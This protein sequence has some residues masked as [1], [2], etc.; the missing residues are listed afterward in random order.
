MHSDKLKQREISGEIISN[1][2]SNFSVSGSRRRYT[3]SVLCFAMVL[4]TTSYVAYNY[5][6]HYLV[7]PSYS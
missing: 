4:A 6:R 5:A 1:M 3:L 7:L 2:M